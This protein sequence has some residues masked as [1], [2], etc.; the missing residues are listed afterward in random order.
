MRFVGWSQDFPS[1]VAE[2]NVA[3]C[4]FSIQNTWQGKRLRGVPQSVP[5]ILVPLLLPP[6]LFLFGSNVLVLA[7]KTRPPTPSLTILSLS[8]P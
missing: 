2:K 4:P 7:M 8:S 3:F 6:F 5:S 1:R